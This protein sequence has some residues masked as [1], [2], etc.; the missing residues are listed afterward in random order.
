MKPA[1]TPAYLERLHAHALLETLLGLVW[2]E[3]TDARK[4][5]FMSLEPRSYTYGKGVGGR[6]YESVPFHPEVL[7]VLIRLNRE[8]GEEYDAC[9]LNRYDNQR[10]QLGWHADDHRPRGSGDAGPEH[11][12]AVVSLGETREIWWKPKAHKGEIPPE[13]RQALGHGSLFVMPVG[14]QDAYYHRIPKCDRVCR[15]RVSLTFRRFA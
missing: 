15:V 5:L 8:R 10:N 2:L 4:E 12:I 11:P 13:W 9:F 14:F 1:Y 7:R 3:A 6:T